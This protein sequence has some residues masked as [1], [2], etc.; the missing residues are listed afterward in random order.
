M[1]TV[2][3]KEVLLQNSNDYKSNRVL[4][5]NGDKVIAEE[6]DGSVVVFENSTLEEVVSIHLNQ[7]LL[8]WEVV[9]KFTN[10]L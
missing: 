9:E 5:Q 6:Q 10:N 7:L 4:H 2:M 3:S 1:S 8:E